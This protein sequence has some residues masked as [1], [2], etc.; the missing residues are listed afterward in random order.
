MKPN[1]NLIESFIRITCGLTLLSLFSAKKQASL[2]GFI[3]IILGALKV[4]EGM[5]R[6]CPIKYMNK[7][8]QIETKKHEHHQ[9]GRVMN[10]S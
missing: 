2:I 3:G 7:A 4:A 8:N 1:L 9:D 10:P 6:F 5:T